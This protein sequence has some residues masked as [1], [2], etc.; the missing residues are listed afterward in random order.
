MDPSARSRCSLGR[1]DRVGARLARARDDAG[2][3][4]CDEPLERRRRDRYIA[5]GVSPGIH[6][7][8]KIMSPGGATDT[9]LG[10]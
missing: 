1:D 7:A 5:W 3:L 2:G 10:A 8:N 9:W 6:E 4:A